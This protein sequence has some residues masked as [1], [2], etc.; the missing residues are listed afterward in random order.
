MV[1]P[2]NRETERP[3]RVPYKVFRHELAPVKSQLMEAFEEVLD[4]GRYV[5]GPEVEDFEKKFAAYCEVAHATGL[6]NGT[7]SLHLTLR[8]MGIEPGDE[9]ITA[10]NSFIASASSVWMAGA[11]P[12]FVDVAEDMN[13]D[14]AL[15][16][17][18]ITPRT[19][20]I[21][22]V[23]LTGRPAKMDQIMEIANRHGLFVL[24]DAA[25][26]IGA[27]LHGKR[28][29]GWGHA[30]SFSLHPLKN[31]HAFGDGGMIVSNDKALVDKVYQLKNHGFA[32]RET[33]EF[34]GY[35]CRLDV[36]QAALL[37]V[38]IKQLDGWIAERRR[39]AF[40]YNE[41]LRPYGVV[42][43]EGA[44]EVHVYGTYVIRVPRRDVLLEHLHKNGVQA[45]VHYRT[46]IHMQ[47]AAQ[48]LGHQP[49]D[50]PVTH[51]QSQ[52]ILSLPLFV[53]MTEEQ[54]E[55]VRQLFA[56]FYG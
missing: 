26:A 3:Y 1:Y 27:R 50:F 28:V 16:E 41:I 5:L 19:K 18:A 2:Q 44:G 31:L 21:I 10:P 32:T 17:A 39:L 22:P 43:D 15:L 56:D 49:E 40:C 51:Q 38:M 48:H 36:L 53:G 35:N 34:W 20:A 30:A 23:H 25:Q 9:V 29:G 8:L 55:L 12:V 54:Q 7:C 52:K 13:L 33:C 46:P 45:L 6:A 37:T 4:T 47:P 11:K 14:P 42:P 24:E